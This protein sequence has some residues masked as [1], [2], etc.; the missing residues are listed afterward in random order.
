MSKRSYSEEFKYEVLFAY[1]NRSLF[2]SRTLFK[3]SNLSKAY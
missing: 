1:N 3:I 2:H